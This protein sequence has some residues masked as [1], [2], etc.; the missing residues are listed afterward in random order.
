MSRHFKALAAPKQTNWV[1]P[2][3]E[4]SYTASRGKTACHLML[5]R[6]SATNK[7]EPRISPYMVLHPVL[8]IQQLIPLFRSIFEVTAPQVQIQFD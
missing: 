5:K 6:F 1:F 8:F 3:N 7:D 2:P 4:L